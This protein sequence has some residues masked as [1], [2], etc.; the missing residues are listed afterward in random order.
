MD[1]SLKFKLLKFPGEEDRFFKTLREKISG[2]DWYHYQTEIINIIY[3]FW[4]E[5][6]EEDCLAAYAIIR[7]LVETS[8]WMDMH[9]E[10]TNSNN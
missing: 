8:A 1:T 2:D 4:L 5:A 3:E 9:S 10:S 7:H 6:D